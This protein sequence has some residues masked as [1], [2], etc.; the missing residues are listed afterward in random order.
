MC[1]YSDIYK[2]N[3]AVKKVLCVFC[4]TLEVFGKNVITEEM[5]YFNQE[6]L[7]MDNL[8]SEF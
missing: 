4:D 5:L 6:K 8:A 1:L 3:T 2:I 7:F